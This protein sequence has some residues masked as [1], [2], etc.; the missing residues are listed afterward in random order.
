MTSRFVPIC[1]LVLAAF[2]G[3]AKS[4]AAITPENDISQARIATK[5]ETYRGTIAIR[6]HGKSPA[7]VKLYQTDYAFCADGRNSFAK[8][9]GLC[10]SVFYSRALLPIC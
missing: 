5:G 3:A 4:R 10:D 8:P 7:A 9:G 2:L 6:N 1:A